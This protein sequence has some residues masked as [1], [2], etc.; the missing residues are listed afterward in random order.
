VEAKIMSTFKKFLTLTLAA[1]LTLPLAP[2]ANVDAQNVTSTLYSNPVGTSYALGAVSTDVGILIKYVG[3]SPAGGVV[4]V[5]AATGDITLET[6]VVGTAT[7]DLTT[8]CPVS[9][10]LGGII[11]VSDTACNTLGEVVDAI[12]A[13][14]NWRAV[15][16]DG[17]RSDNSVNTLNT[18]AATSAS[19]PTGIPLLKDTT[20]ALNVS[21]ALVP[22]A[23]RSDIRLYLDSSQP[24]KFKRNPFKGDQPVLLRANG[25][26]TGTGADFFDY[27]SV[28]QDAGTCPTAA[29]STAASI[30]CTASEVV[31]NTYTE[32]GGTTTVNK[33]YDYSEVGLPGAQDAKGIARLRAATTFTA[34]LFS[35]AGLTSQY[36]AR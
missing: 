28:I 27:I 13:S 24:P 17:L 30:I 20:V 29:A 3:T 21:L 34:A 11:D 26:F 18:L 8:E 23:Y 7:A 6:G 2:L 14:P 4:T 5:A 19:S 25:T 35:A 36:M 12:N 15:I 22:F 31:A 1:A 10:A 32:P 33:T 16:V 9:G